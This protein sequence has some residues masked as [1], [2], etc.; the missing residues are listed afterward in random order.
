MSGFFTDHVSETD[1]LIAWALVGEEERQQSQI[2]LI[3]S[4]NMVSRAVLDALGHQ[5]TNKTLEGYPASVSMAAGNSLTSPSRRR[6]TGRWS[7]SARAM[8]M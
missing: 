1:P 8:P 2:E 6:S 5:F 7:C 4:E 3:A